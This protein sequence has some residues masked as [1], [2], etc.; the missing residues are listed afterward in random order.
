MRNWQRNLPMGLRLFLEMMFVYLLLFPIYMDTI[1]FPPLLPFFITVTFGALLYGVTIWRAKKPWHASYAIPIVVGLSMLTGFHISIALFLGFVLFWRVTV[2][3]SEDM[4]GSEMKVLFFT[5]FTGLFYYVWL[6]QAPLRHVLILFVMGQF[7]ATVI[8]LATVNTLNASGSGQKKRHFKYVGALLLGIASLGFG[9]ALFTPVLTSVFLFLV[10]TITA[11]VGWILSPI[12]FLFA[13]IT[14]TDVPEESLPPMGEELVPDDEEYI[15]INVDETFIGS[16]TFYWILAAT[17]LLLAFLYVMRNL[18]TKQRTIE[19]E[20]YQ[21]TSI[22]PS[23]SDNGWTWFKN[24]V[25]PKHEIR[26]SFLKLEMALGKKG[27]GRMYPQTAEEWLA[28]IPVDPEEKEHLTTTYQRVRYGKE[29][30][31]SEDK[32]AFHQ[33]VASI[34]QRVKKEKKTD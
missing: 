18:R 23:T 15:P 28:T 17:L 4:E 33:T 6:Q 34:I 24:K 8:T 16:M 20:D 14:P 11:A 21:D 13:S 7:F 10:R 25:K 32:R 22:T 19:K 31:T 26:R 9:A 27:Y 1:G 3:L 12:L 29:E 30:I 2:H 5:I